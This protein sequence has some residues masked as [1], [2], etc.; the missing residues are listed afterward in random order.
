MHPAIEN[1]RED[2]RVIE[3]VVRAMHHAAHRLLANRPVDA[4]VLRQSIAFLEGFLE[5]CHY[6]KEEEFL[7]PALVTASR[8]TGGGPVAELR[9][10][11]E[12]TR[13]YFGELKQALKRLDEGGRQAEWEAAVA[14]TRYHTALSTHLHEEEQVCLRYAERALDPEELN[15]LMVN[16]AGI[17]AGVDGKPERHELYRAVAE[18]VAEA[19]EADEELASMGVGRI[20]ESAL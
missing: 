11:H 5:H 15:L 6:R 12:R 9:A 16:F 20:W 10:D 8:F 7:F 2:H 1:L 17:E 19:L 4:G 13:R 14:L 3:R 18:D